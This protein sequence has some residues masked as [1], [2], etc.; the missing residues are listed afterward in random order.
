MKISVLTM[1]SQTRL[2]VKFIPLILGKIELPVPSQLSPLD[3]FALT[4]K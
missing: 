1:L 3:V 2:A 4:V